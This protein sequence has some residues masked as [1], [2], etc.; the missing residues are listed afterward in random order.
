MRKKEDESKSN[1]NSYLGTQVTIILKKRDLR[2]LVLRNLHSLPVKS[3]FSKYHFPS[4]KDNYKC[5][6][7]NILRYVVL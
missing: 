2:N 6:P 3:P 1:S 5:L 7:R 4:R